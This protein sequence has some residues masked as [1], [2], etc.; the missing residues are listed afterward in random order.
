[1][2]LHRFIIVAVSEF[3]MG[4]MENK[5]LN[6]FNTKFVLANAET[7]SDF[8]FAN[9]QSVVGHEYFHNWTGNRVTCRDW[10]Q[11]SLKEGLTVFRDQE[12]T[13]AMMGGDENPAA[14]AV[15]R[16]ED[17]CVVRQMQ[18]GE[19][20]GP[21]AHPV[22]PESYAEIS[23]FYTATVYRKGAEVVRMY[24]TL[25]GREGFRKGMDLYFAR[26][27]GQAV[28]CDDFRA[29]MADANGRDRAQ[30]ERWYSQAGTPRVTVTTHYDETA[31]RYCVTLEQGYGR[32]PAAA[33]VSQ[34]GPLLIPFA[35]GLL[36]ATGADIP[37]KLLGETA[38]Q[39]TTRVLEL[40]EVRQ[41]FTF[42]DIAAK[43][44]PSLLRDFSAPVTVEYD[45]DVDELAFLLAHDSDP[46]NRW[47]A[48]QRL[49]TRELLALAARSAAGEG[50]E[51]SV[52]LVEAF[53]RVLTDA[54]LSP[55]FR[56]LALTLP[57][58][59]YLAEQMAE[60]DPAAVHA[61][62]QFVRKELASALTAEWLA[63][64]EENLTPGAYQPTPEAAGR[65]ALKNLS[66]AYLAE[67]ADPAA[68]VRFATAQY[69]TANN[70]TDRSAAL[71]ALLS[72]SVVAGDDVA[73]QALADFYGRFEAEPLV[74]DKWFSFQATRSGTAQRPTIARVRALM[75]HPAFTLKNPNRARSLI[76]AFCS[77]NPAE[78]HAADGSG[79][80]Y[81][82]EQV[83]ALDALNPQVAA[84]LARMLERWRAFIPALREPMRA[85]LETVAQRVKSR[86]VLE[87][88]QKALA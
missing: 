85:A 15:K 64:Y 65:R 23:N 33:Q 6:I 7:A 38:E 70:M 47:E 14:R 29:A 21:M 3:N 25:L 30:F 22:R 32:T 8:D 88:V 27:D 83:V 34:T 2:D 28:T 39:G 35:V 53:R 13:A 61:A 11:L 5:G 84:R 37:L 9:V 76:F 75:S 17:V 82:A 57:A 71:A 51:M 24:Q 20:S 78:F 44:V 79:Y 18:F 58:E 60:S 4:A 48:G 56:A 36:G 46:F 55:S 54:A 87:V 72:A 49:A 77:A 45:Y 81:W 86:D 43:P 31:Q 50:L 59:T 74:I 73:E 12:F 62:R 42:V 1:L 63:A 40:T 80:E 16:I 67:L 26:H 19:D 41:T 68:A 52:S 10:F 69:S 66:L